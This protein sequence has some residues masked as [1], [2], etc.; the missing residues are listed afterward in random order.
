MTLKEIA[1]KANVSAATV[2][3]VLNGNS[4]KAASVETQ[5]KIWKIAKESGY[6]PNASAQNLKAGEDLTRKTCSISCLYARRTSD[7]KDA[8]FTSI[9]LAAEKE[10]LRA[11]CIVK[12]SFTALDIRNPL[13]AKTIV[14][15]NT[16]GILILGRCDELTLTFLTNHFRNIV[17]V[18]VNPISQKYDQVT[19]DGYQIGTMIMNKFYENGYKRIAYVGEV[20]NEIRYHAYCD[21][22]H[23]HKLPTDKHLI[24]DTDI[25]SEGGYQGMKALLKRTSALD[26]VFCMGDVIAMGVSKA[27]QEAGLTIPKDIALLSV[28]NI[29]AAEFISPTLST[30]NVP[31]EEMGKIAVKVLLDRIHGGHSEPL[32][33]QLPYR[34][35]E[36]ESFRSR[37]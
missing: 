16:D 27:I 17:Y 4:T 30:V 19:C 13:I 29:D 28:D 20:Q 31:T 23:T 35:V 7:P 34:L 36:R 22:F 5:K 32:Y 2:S 14:E 33:I 3:R 6:V 18:G 1:A 37:Q 25:T 15:N 26:A 12:F 21:F 8:F 10:A 11:G 9:T 24:V